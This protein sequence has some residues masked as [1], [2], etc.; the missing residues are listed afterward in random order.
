M[1][2]G[3]FICD[4]D[5]TRREPGNPWQGI[6]VYNSFDIELPQR[7]GIATFKKTFSPKAPKKEIKSAKDHQKDPVRLKI[8]KDLRR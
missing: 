1:K 5:Q 2:K 8:H 3:I 7:E 6:K 4:P